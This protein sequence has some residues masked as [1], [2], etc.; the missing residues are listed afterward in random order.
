[1]ITE[2]FALMAVAPAN[3]HKIHY[4]RET[5]YLPICGTTSSEGFECV[6]DTE[7]DGHKHMNLC[8]R[9]ESKAARDAAKL[10]A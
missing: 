7:T 5:D 4:A 1:M 6:G 3:L 10:A 9:C 8:M 2:H